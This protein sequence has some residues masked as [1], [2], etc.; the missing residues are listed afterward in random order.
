M[1]YAT[2]LVLLTPLV[3]AQTEVPLPMT[4]ADYLALYS[5]FTGGA[6][7]Q[8]N[9]QCGILAANA[10]EVRAEQPNSPA[11]FPGQGGKCEQGKCV[12]DA[13]YTCGTC[14]TLKSHV[15]PMCCSAKNTSH[16]GDAWC[17]DNCA[18][19]TR[20][21]DCAEH[22]S[23]ITGRTCHGSLDYCASPYGGGACDQDSNCFSGLCL[24][25]LC[26]CTS[27]YAC[28]YCTQS[29][30]NL[31]EGA[32]CASDRDSD[33]TSNFISGGATCE[34]N[35]DC[36]ANSLCSERSHGGGKVCSC[37]PGSGCGDCSQST[38]L[39]ISGNASCGCPS[40]DPCEP[41]GFCSGAGQCKCYW[42]YTGINCDVLPCTPDPC[43]GKP[44]SVC[45]IAALS[46][47]AVCECTG[48]YTRG[49][50]G[51][52]DVAPTCTSDSDCGVFAP[53]PQASNPEFACTGYLDGCV[54]DKYGGECIDGSC[55]CRNGFTCNT[56]TAKGYD[57]DEATGGGICTGD[58]DC[59]SKSTSNHC[60]QGRCVCANGFTCA[61]CNFEQQG[62][63]LNQTCPAAESGQVPPPAPEPTP[64]PT[65]PTPP[66]PS[67]P[68]T[69]VPTPCPEDQDCTPFIDGRPTANTGSRSRGSA[70]AGVVVALVVALVSSVVQ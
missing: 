32:K 40:P 18:G 43:A 64:D 11:N 8:Y 5:N 36:G 1:F 63:G 67:L 38:T 27:G 21:S 24:G 55:S 13:G 23:C 35:T 20:S 26:S 41:N 19:T 4:D 61:M 25:N 47:T 68:P 52:C 9:F 17:H 48:G 28:P 15:K 2:V 62:L 33:S 49:T 16:Y 22:C 3:V 7:C 29:Q 45:V 70:G 10:Y 31:R 44:N 39:L 54:S 50:S 34:A 51:N 56:C 66:T 65:P 59:Q 42:P 37:S 57:C 12:C 46:S 60:F 53:I 30:Q 58:S 6:D 14:H 69:P